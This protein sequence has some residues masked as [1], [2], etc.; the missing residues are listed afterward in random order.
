MKNKIK[1]IILVTLLAFILPNLVLNKNRKKVSAYTQ[2]DIVFYGNDIS[3]W[4]GDIDFKKMKSVSNF[5][6]IR[7]GYGTKIDKKFTTYMDNALKVGLNVGVYIYSLAESE[8]EAVNEAN[9][10]ISTLVGYGY[11]KGKLTF[12]VYFDYEEN[13]IITSKTKKENTDIINAFASTIFKAGFY[14]GVYM[15]ASHFNSYVNADSLVCDVWLAQYFGSNNPSDFSKKL[16]NSHKKV[17]MWQFAAGAYTYNGKQITSHIKYSGK[18]CGV[19]SDSIDENWCFVDYP[20]KIKQG[21]Y[22]GFIKQNDM[23]NS[24]SNGK[25]DPISSSNSQ[26]GSNNTVQSS[27]NSSIVNGGNVVTENNNK[28]LQNGCNGSIVSV[29]YFVIF[30]IVAS[31]LLIYKSYKKQK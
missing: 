9:W 30:G 31:V 27:Q 24:N 6:I 19:S 10:V 8:Q 20:S 26:N 22:N 18:E 14:A 2:N 12:P 13:Y 25:S 1:Y 29:K 3:Y 28:Q 4:Q 15:G 5:A 16:N 23:Q 17:K 7:I 11:D 21:G